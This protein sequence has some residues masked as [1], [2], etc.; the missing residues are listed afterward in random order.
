MAPIRPEGRYSLVEPDEKA[1]QAIEDR[2]TIR[3]IK[4]K[5]FVLTFSS[6]F[7]VAVVVG[8][9]AASMGHRSAPLPEAQEQA[10]RHLT[11]DV[12]ALRADLVQLKAEVAQRD[13]DTEWKLN[14]L[15]TRK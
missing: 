11:E 10:V 15:L 8:V 14:E 5:G 1:R 9:T 6:H 2:A 7:V 13:R 4:G 12:A 3:A